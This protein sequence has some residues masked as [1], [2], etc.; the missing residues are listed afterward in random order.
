MSTW[1]GNNFYF[2]GQGV[3]L[4]GERDALTGKPKGL[5]SVGNVTDLSI[6]T[7]VEVLEH[8]EAQT[9][10]R[11]I[12][13]RLT[14]ETTVEVVATLENFV[15]ENLKL[16]LRG[17][18]TE[19]DGAAITAE[20]VLL[21][22]G[23]VTPLANIKIA[24]TPTF[25][26]EFGATTLTLFVDDDTPYDYKL[27]SEA[28]SVLFND[29]SLTPVDKLMDEGETITALTVGATTV[30]TMA[31]VPAFAEVGLKATPGNITWTVDPTN[32]QTGERAYTILAKTLTTVTL[33]WNTTGGTYGSAGDIMFDGFEFTTDYTFT[34]Y[35]K[36]DGLTQGSSER[37]LRFEGLNTADDFKP[38]VVEVFKFVTDPAA[39]FALISDEV[40]QFELTG[41]ALA[42]A[43]QTTGSK[44]FKVSLLR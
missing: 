36:V 21:Y 18:S 34:T 29:G 28:G 6:N 17:D 1:D 8:K 12:D 14:T 33:D 35:N 9:G 5:R 32:G 20:E 19:V 24:A 31:A 37:Y 38:V 15:A 41:N 16:A 43:L 25:V 10:Q 3:V 40:Q 11:S 30:V 26:L 44:F 7:A 39:A 42:D 4:I 13:L 22:A 27:N 23:K 2:S